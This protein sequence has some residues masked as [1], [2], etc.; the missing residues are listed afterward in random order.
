MLQHAISVNSKHSINLLLLLPIKSLV[1]LTGNTNVDRLRFL[2]NQQKDWGSFIKTNNIDGTEKFFNPCEIIL[3]KEH[4]II[5]KKKIIEPVVF[6]QH[7]QRVVEIIVK[8]P[9]ICSSVTKS[10]PCLNGSKCKYAHTMEQL[11]PSLCKWTSCKN[12]NC[13]YLH[14]HESVESF[15][16][17]RKINF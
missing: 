1:S 17:R 6:I 2:E 10:I 13:S 11:E 8:F 16:K 9:I 14:K 12:T 4:G 15:C 5:V 3:P 7:I